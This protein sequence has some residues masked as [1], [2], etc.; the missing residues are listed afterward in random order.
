MYPDFPI[1]RLNILAKTIADWVFDEAK[2]CPSDMTMITDNLD[3]SVLTSR[4]MDDLY[5]QVCGEMLYR[6]LQYRK[7]LAEVSIPD[8]STRVRS[9]TEHK[10]LN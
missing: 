1:E 5:T 10:F 2:V 6:C 3:Y 7:A 8:E 4:I 9:S